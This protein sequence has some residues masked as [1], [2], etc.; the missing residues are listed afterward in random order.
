MRLVDPLTAAFSEEL[1]DLV[2]AV[3]ERGW[4]ILRLSLSWRYLRLSNDLISAL[5]TEALFSLDC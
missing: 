3:G 2:A 5:T 4:L 1:F